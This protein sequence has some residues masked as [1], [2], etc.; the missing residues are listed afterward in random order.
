MLPVSVPV[1]IPENSSG[2]L[3]DEAAKANLALAIAQTCGD[4]TRLALAATEKA[5]IKLFHT[6]CKAE[7]L[8]RAS[9]IAET[10]RQPGKPLMNELPIA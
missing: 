6:A 1:V 4:D 7:Q 9:D 5:A 8:G 3:E 2:D 10:F